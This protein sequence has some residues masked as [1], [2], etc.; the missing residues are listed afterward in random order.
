MSLFLEFS[1]DF[2]TVR[3]EEKTFSFPWDPT[4]KSTNQYISLFLESGDEISVSCSKYEKSLKIK[5]NWRD[6][7]TVEISAKEH[8]KWMRKHIN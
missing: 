2:Q 1:S 4:G 8:S 6:G 7:L 5:N 3:K